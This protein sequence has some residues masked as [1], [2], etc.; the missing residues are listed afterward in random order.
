[1]KAAGLSVNRGIIIDDRL[2]ANLPGFDAVGECAEHRGQVYGL[3]EP[4]YAQAENPALS[5]GMVAATVIAERL[6]GAVML[7]DPANAEKAALPGDAIGPYLH[8]G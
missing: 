8:K 4:C 3:V 5:S 1:M 2:A 7:S 6:I